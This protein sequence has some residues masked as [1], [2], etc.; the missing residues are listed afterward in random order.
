MFRVPLGTM[1]VIPCTSLP[2]VP[3]AVVLAVVGTVAD[4]TFTTRPA[5]QPL[6]QP[7][8]RGVAAIGR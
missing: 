7:L 4:E 8:A 3:K 6:K 2:L 1:S 5:L